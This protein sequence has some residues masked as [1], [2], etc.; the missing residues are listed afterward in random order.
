M[1]AEKGKLVMTI[2]KDQKLGVYFVVGTLI[3]LCENCYKSLVR[4]NLRNGNKVEIEKVVD[5]EITGIY[6]GDGCGNDSKI[7]C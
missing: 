2:R 3:T 7:P 1:P 4:T 5:T 6:E